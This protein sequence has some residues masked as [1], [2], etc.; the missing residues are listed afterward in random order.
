[1]QENITRKDALHGLASLGVG[2]FVGTQCASATA[3]NAAETSSTF[4]NVKTDFGA[5]GD[6][7]TD[8]TRAFQSAL[9]SLPWEGGTVY[10]PVGMYRITETLFRQTGAFRMVGEG[11]PTVNEGP[12]RLWG[13]VIVGDRPGMDLVVVD[14]QQTTGV[15]HSGPR[16][17]DL[18]FFDKT[19]SKQGTG[20]RIRL[21]NRWLFERC[22]FRELGTGVEIDSDQQGRGGSIQGGDASW[23]SFMNCH[24]LY[25]HTGVFVP[26][27]GGFLAEGGEVTSA[28]RGFDIRGGSQ[29]RIFGVKADVCEDAFIHM[30]G[31]G[32]M[33]FGLQTEKCGTAVRLHG[34]DRQKHKIDGTRNCVWGLHVSGLGGRTASKG[35]HIT[36]EASLCMVGMISGVSI[37]KQ[38]LV[39]DE[40]RQTQKAFVQNA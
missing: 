11:A 39:V 29:H 27:S 28:H 32:G 10:V 1:M 4:L 9:D 14:H 15:G 6:G 24:F 19:K 17:L 2:A 38:L 34:N 3:Q 13:S 20:V 33:F 25:C 37:N 8:D 5:K 36:K 12:R 35:V 18:G 30:E 26:R 31:T 40:G 7:I 16:F 23:G 21:W 22:S